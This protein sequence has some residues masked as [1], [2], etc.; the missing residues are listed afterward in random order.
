MNPSRPRGGLYH[1]QV[2][3]MDDKADTKTF[4]RPSIKEIGDQYFQIPVWKLQEL[5]MRAAIL[6]F[7]QAFKQRQEKH[8]LEVVCSAR[9]S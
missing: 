3:L 5:P 7:P 1:H 8:L 6:V 4:S 2:R 9:L